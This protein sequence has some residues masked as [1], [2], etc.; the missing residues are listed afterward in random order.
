M[1]A[2]PVVVKECVVLRVK[3]GQPGAHTHSDILP[4]CLAGRG[5]PHSA[6]HTIGPGQDTARA[7][8]ASYT[9]CGWLGVL[10]VSAA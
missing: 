9:I 1:F 2:L 8:S 6:W 10:A 3:G 4:G 5:C 7:L